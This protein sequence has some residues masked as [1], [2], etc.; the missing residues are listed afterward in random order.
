MPKTLFT[1]TVTDGSDP[2]LW[3]RIRL[4]RFLGE[5][6]AWKVHLEADGNPSMAINLVG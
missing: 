3:H 4:K 5:N 2:N 1:P 6:M